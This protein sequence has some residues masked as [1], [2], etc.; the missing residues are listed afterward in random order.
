MFNAESKPEVT[1][2]YAVIPEPSEVRELFERGKSALHELF[3]KV[4]DGREAV[5]L[6]RSEDLFG[7]EGRG[8]R[9]FLLTE[10]NLLWCHE[11]KDLFVLEPGDLLGLQELEGSKL[12][13][14][15]GEF[16]VRAYEYSASEFFSRIEGDSGAT[17]LWRKFLASQYAAM[18]GI[19]AL[20][21][22]GEKVFAPHVHSYQAGDTIIAEGSRGT[23]VYTLL[24]GGR[25]DV[26]VDSVK[27]GEVHEDQLFGVFAALTDSPRSAS[28]IAAVPSLAV[29][30]SREDF[31][32]LI[33]NR[34]ELALKAMKDLSATIVDLNARLVQRE[35]L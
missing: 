2:M 19:V 12:G 20:R 6:P 29:V 10:G 11:N 27:V 25:A 30:V 1:I 4:H 31:L 17:V 8:G 7:E 16:A 21:M 26:V 34:P 3:Q 23:D 22:E 35:I 13:R 9:L 32:E 5:L 33:S 14:I 24:E 18:S 15:R 28:V